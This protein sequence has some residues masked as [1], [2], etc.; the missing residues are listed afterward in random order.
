MFC[1]FSGLSK[2]FCFALEYSLG[3][4]FGAAF[5]FALAFSFAFVVFGFGAGFLL[6]AFGNGS[7]GFLEATSN[8]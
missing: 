5:A 2:N 6:G 3:S 1:G 4:F 8:L 7:A